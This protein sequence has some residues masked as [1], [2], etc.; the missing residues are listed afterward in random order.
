MDSFYYFII[1]AAGVLSYYFYQRVLTGANPRRRIQ[2]L[3]CKPVPRERN[4]D[5]VFGLDFLVK[6]VNQVKNHSWLEFT[7]RHFESLGL[8]TCQLNILGRRL[9][10]TIDPENLKAIHVSNFKSWGIPPNRRKRVVPFIGDG[11]FTNDGHAWTKSRKLLR[12]SFERSH[13]NELSMIERHTQDLMR[14][15]P[16][17]GSTV[18]LQVLFYRF[19]MNSATDFLLGDSSGAGFTF[20]NDFEAAF[21]RCLNKVGGAG[22]FLT[23]G[24]SRDIQYEND[25]KFVHGQSGFQSPV[26]RQTL[27]YLHVFSF[28]S[29]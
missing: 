10:F 6:R 24:T 7:H 1:L 14:Q 22:R 11:I 29:L 13:L 3:G 18:D 17:D 8:A 2:K 27:L 15:I 23:L 28:Q 25:L 21:D 19:T 4:W 20:G 16:T 5:P 12:P 26:G 9:L